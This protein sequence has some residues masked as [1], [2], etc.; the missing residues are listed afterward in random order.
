MK[1]IL[2]S[3]ATITMLLLFIN[4]ESFGQ[5]QTLYNMT[6]LR[7]S[8]NNNP[9]RQHKCN[10]FIGLPVLSSTYLDVVNTGFT[11]KDLFSAETAEGKFDFEVDQFYNSLSSVNHLNLENQL[12]IFNVG[13]W[14]KDYQVTLDMTNKTVQ[15]F[16]YPQSVFN[17]KD[18]NYY[19]DGSSLNLSNFGEDFSNYN[20]IGLAVSKEVI[21]GLTVGVKLKYLVGIANF[22]TKKFDLDWETSTEDASNYAYTYTTKF[23]FRTSSMMPIEPIYNENGIPDSLAGTDEFDD[24]SPT[25]SAI[26]SMV[27]QKNR[28]LGVDIGVV[29]NLNNMFEFSASVVDLGYIRWKNNALIATTEESEFDFTGADA[30]KYAPVGLG[31]F[32]TFEDTDLR[33]VAIDSFVNDMLDT[34]ISLSNPNFENKAYTTSLSTKMYFG[35]N[36]SPVSWFDIG[37]LYRGYFYKNKLHSA[38][39]TSANIN[40]WKGWSYS[41]AH[42]IQYKKYNNIGMG[43]AYKLGPFQW[44][45]ISDNIAL[46]IYGLSSLKAANT[47]I[48]S[49]KQLTFHVGFNL[50]FG[51]RN[52]KDLGLLD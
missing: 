36:Y 7:L 23:D 35:A 34:L 26:M 33:Q 45:A 28:G 24:F 37:L 19:E 2:I 25:T 9:A 32:S 16:S 11:Y 44:Y 42:T 21:P 29:Y 51:C 46:P 48:K 52:K 5:D 38:F 47:L 18:G 13:F 10:V 43:L 12:S 30:N 39:T 1:K 4:S 3:I 50:T 27:F 31:I 40:L 49:T 20:E 17:I 6:N 14:V 41:L 15:R 22:T 8:M